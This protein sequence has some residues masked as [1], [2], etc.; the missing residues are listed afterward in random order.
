MKNNTFTTVNLDDDQERDTFLDAY[1]PA[2]GIRLANLLGINGRGAKRAANGLMNYA[3]NIRAA[4]SCRINGY[5]QSALN[6]EEIAERIYTEDI[7]EAY[8][9]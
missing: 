4:R 9:W 6:F 2:R 3:Q 7:P 5:T 1:E 8:K